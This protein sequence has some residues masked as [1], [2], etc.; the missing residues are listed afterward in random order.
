MQPYTY[1]VRPHTSEI[2]QACSDGDLVTVQRL[3][4]AGK[5]SPLDV[6]EYGVTLLQVGESSVD[7]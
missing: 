6:T 5:A 4:A 3:F 1:N 7:L 2:F